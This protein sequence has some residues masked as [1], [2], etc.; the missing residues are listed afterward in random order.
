[1]SDKTPLRFQSSGRCSACGWNREVRVFNNGIVQ[2]VVESTS[3]QPTDCC[4]SCDAWSALSIRP[5]DE[6]GEQL[7]KAVE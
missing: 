2:F 4:E 7:V 6:S 5:L 3:S 1:M